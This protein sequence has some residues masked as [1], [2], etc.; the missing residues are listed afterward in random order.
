MIP[1]TAK[2]L[3]CPSNT[4]TYLQLCLGA[5]SCNPIRSQWDLSVTNP[6]CLPSKTIYLSGSLINVIVDFVLVM[7]PMPYVWRLRAPLGQRLILA[8]MFGLGFFVCIVSVIRLT[9]VMAIPAGDLDATYN[10]KDFIIWSTVEINIGLLCS[11]LP[12][13]RRLLSAIGLGRLFSRGSS[14]DKAG[15]GELTPGQAAVRNTQPSSAGRSLGGSTSRLKGG[16]LWTSMG[17]TKIDSDEDAYE[18]IDH[19][20]NPKGESQAEIETGGRASSRESERS[21]SGTAG[22]VVQRDWSVKVDETG[23]SGGHQR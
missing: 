3:N 2:P 18:M 17:L 21:A 13:M 23:A 12:S 11:C 9:E 4:T 6:K 7:M 5:F 10:L 16:G 14:A 15:T 8:G 19:R 20:A 22:I 1:P